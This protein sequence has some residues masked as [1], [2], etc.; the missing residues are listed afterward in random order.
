MQF[1]TKTTLAS[2]LF[3][4]L[5]SSC[6]A[7]ESHKTLDKEAVQTA[8]TP[9][10]G[11]RYALSL[12]QVRNASTY[13]RGIFSDNSD[14]LG[15]QARTILQTR[16]SQSGR[17]DLLD[18]ENMEQLARESQ[19]G[20]RDQNLAGAE[21]VISG[22]V[23]EFGRRT[24][25]DRALFGLFGRGRKQ[26][27]YSVVSL[28]LVDVSTSRVLYSVQGA[29]EYELAEREILGTGGNSGYDSTLNGKVLDLCIVDAVNDLVAG[30]ERGAFSLPKSGGQ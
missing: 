24:T 13:L 30:L 19:L 26:V 14:R 7:T 29:A 1:I 15:G 21:L 25:G 4:L 3:A 6:S 11:P 5:F 27:A 28:S 2:L 23:T 17:F 10:S 8:A 9:Y 12:G 20:G 18:R 22:E 16:L